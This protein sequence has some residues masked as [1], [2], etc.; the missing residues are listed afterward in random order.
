MIRI[1]MVTTETSPF[2]KTGGLADM[3]SALSSS[4]ISMDTD[5][6][7]VMPRY[8]CVDRDTLEK[9]PPPLYV[10]TPY[11]EEWA[12]VYRGELPSSGVPVY[13]IDHEELYG[14][15]GIYVYTPE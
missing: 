10:P 4:L 7:I 3:V 14:R 6:R 15:A 5:V 9:N 2:A 8:Y 1:L 13:F 12:A 11:S